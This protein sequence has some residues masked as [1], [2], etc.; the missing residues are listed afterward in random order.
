MYFAKRGG[1]L[2]AGGGSMED[3]CR[4]LGVFFFLLAVFTTLS[5]FF[6]EG[7]LGTA[8]TSSGPLRVLEFCNARRAKLEADMGELWEL[9]LSVSPGLYKWQIVE[10]QAG[11]RWFP[12]ID[13]V[14]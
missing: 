2:A 12:V 3:R 6:V 7:V 10:Q 1:D 8:V 14:Q 13:H 11:D 5:D 9:P 4:F